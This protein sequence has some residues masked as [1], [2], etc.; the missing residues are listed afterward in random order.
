[1]VQLQQ[2]QALDKLITA[3]STVAIPVQQRED[4][5]GR[6]HAI[7]HP[8]MD[9]T[10]KANTGSLLRV[11]LRKL[12]CE[13]L[14]ALGHLQPVPEEGFGLSLGPAPALWRAGA[15]LA[16]AVAIKT[17]EA[18]KINHGGEQ[19]QVEAKP[20]E[21]R[22]GHVAL[23][24]ASRREVA[25]GLEQHLED[26]GEHGHEGDHFG[27]QQLVLQEL[28]LYHLCWQHSR[29]DLRLRLVFGLLHNPHK[30]LPLP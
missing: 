17:L 3:N 15:G 30:G 25:V 14:E 26:A 19:P 2:L 27:L 7:L 23:G 28:G 4:V 21:G 24:G 10:K 1:M 6:P 11:V 22:D 12:L 20:Q 18:L 9:G 5:A 13:P 29:Q 8:V 16:A